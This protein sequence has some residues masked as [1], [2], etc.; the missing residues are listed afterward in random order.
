MGEEMA[1]FW[2]HMTSA[3]DN[4]EAE[5]MLMLLPKQ[6]YLLDYVLFCFF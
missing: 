3:V 2:A 4:I 6:Q 1:P 5:W